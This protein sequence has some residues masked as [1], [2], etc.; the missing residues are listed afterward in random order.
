MI[1]RLHMYF[2]VY[3]VIVS[4]QEGEHN[5]GTLSQIIILSTVLYSIFLRPLIGIYIHVHVC[6][7]MYMYTH[8]KNVYSTLA[9]EK[10]KY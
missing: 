3:Q 7:Y 4:Q 8:G 6:V 9:C 10:W 2:H 5:G 1:Y